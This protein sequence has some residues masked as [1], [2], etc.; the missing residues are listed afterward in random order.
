VNTKIIFDH[1][2]RMEMRAW[3]RAR[4]HGLVYYTDKKV[5]ATA[6]QLGW[7]VKCLEPK[8]RLDGVSRFG[9]VAKFYVRHR[10]DGD[11]LEKLLM[12][13]L[14]GVVWTNDEQVDEGMWTKEYERTEVGVRLTIYVID[15]EVAK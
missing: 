2:I 1:F 5:T 8:L 7:E 11:N 14:Q 3:K 15:Q 9:F 12:D 10:G 13:A 6:Q 4:R